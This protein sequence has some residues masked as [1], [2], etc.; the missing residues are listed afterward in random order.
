MGK[1]KFEITDDKLL[2]QPL[3][4]QELS[5]LIGMDSFTYMVSDTDQSILALKD[6]SYGS[7]IH[8]AADLEKQV[9]TIF[10]EEK[11]LS[12]AP[13]KVKIAFLNS[14]SSFSCILVS[15]ILC[16]S[17]SVYSMSE[18]FFLSFRK[19]REGVHSGSETLGRHFHCR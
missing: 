11:Y 16:S 17:V 4:S 18:L 13:K 8:K 9:K 7:P 10:A 14:K 6:F 3:A 19:E 1:I 5:I 15:T 12:E 2:K